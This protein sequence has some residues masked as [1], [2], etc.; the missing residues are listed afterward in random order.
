MSEEERSRLR[1]IK[2]NLDRR[3]KITYLIRKYFKDQ[4]FLEVETPIRVSTLAP[5]LQIEPFSCENFYL[6]T[7]PELHMKRL[8]AAGYDKIFQLSHCFR[9]GEQGKYHNPEFT[10]LEWY[11]INANYVKIIKDMENLLI[12]VAS[13][14]GMRNSIHYK[15]KEIYIESP[16]P[17]LSVKD[18]FLRFADW[19]PIDQFDPVRFDVDLVTKVVPCLSLHI[20]TVLIDYPA[21]VGSLARLHPD[22]SLI[23][24]RAEVFIGGLELANI[25]SELNNVEEQRERFL[26]EIQKIAFEKNRTV[27]MPIHFLE[28]LSSLPNCGGIALGVD[29]LVMLFCNADFID[30]VVTFTEDTL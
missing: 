22:N 10:L 26:A 28:S 5:E 30:D 3:A 1:R 18:A 14:L 12:A 11:R 27:P 20:P 16:W 24:E 2:P 8:L 6:T 23:A 13:G 21:S 15:G 19:N 29:R 17:C 25:Y 9:K 7:S 4:K